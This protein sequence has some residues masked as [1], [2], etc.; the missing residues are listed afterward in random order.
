MDIMR[1]GRGSDTAAT[2]ASL[3]PETLTAKL[4]A[5]APSAPAG[6]TIPART[7]SQHTCFGGLQDMEEF[8]PLPWL[9]YPS[10]EE[11]GDYILF[12]PSRSQI[13]KKNVPDLKGHKA[14]SVSRDG[15]LLVVTDHKPFNWLFFLNLFTR[16]RIYLPNRARFLNCLAFSAAPTSTSC[17]VVSFSQNRNRFLISTWTPGETE[18][19]IHHYS[20]TPSSGRWSKCI[21]SNGLV[22][23]LSNCGFLGVFDPCNATW[24]VLPVKPW[25]CAVFCDIVATGK[26][27]LMMEHDGN[28]FVMS[29][30]RGKKTTT[31][32]CLN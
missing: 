23:A 19:T 31:G 25:G 3:F 32:R 26:Q 11:D 8:Q 9:F 6:Y 30:E 14:L 4:I 10:E 13:Y 22:Y 18:W 17:L 15:W 29:A 16:E 27:V 5:Q 7:K 20:R 21:F 28:I 1:T 2:P 12:D 24:V